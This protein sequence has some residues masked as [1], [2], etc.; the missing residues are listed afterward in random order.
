MPL[1]FSC[2]EVDF[3]SPTLDKLLPNY[4]LSYPGFGLNGKLTSTTSCVV[5][6]V[7]T[8]CGNVQALTS[9]ILLNADFYQSVF[10]IGDVSVKIKACAIV[11]CII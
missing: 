6:I 9:A 8:S 3:L 11:G 4:S 2:A 10:L 7:A 1:C 5:F